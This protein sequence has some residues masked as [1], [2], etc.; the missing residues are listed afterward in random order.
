MISIF[1][2]GAGNLHSIENA[3]EK[4]GVEHRIVRSPAEIA[5]AQRLILPGVG[6]FGQMMRRIDAI[7]AREV[8]VERV[9][10]GVPLFGICLGMQALFERSEDGWIPLSGTQPAIP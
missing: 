2:Y 10:D 4:V 1:D 7:G 5:S 9:R 3:L 6:H 8:L